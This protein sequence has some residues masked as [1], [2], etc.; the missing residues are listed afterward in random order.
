MSALASSTI[1]T[2]ISHDDRG[3]TEEHVAQ[4][5]PAADRTYVGRV[6]PLTSANQSC[7]A[8]EHYTNV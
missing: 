8:A 4:T 5:L 7:Q 2:R 3:P 6:R 1:D